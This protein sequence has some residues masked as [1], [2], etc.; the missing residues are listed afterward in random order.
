MRMGSRSEES[1]SRRQVFSAIA[2]VTAF[3]AVAEPSNAVKFE[4]SM[5]FG[6]L[7]VPVYGAYSGKYDGKG[8][9]NKYEGIKVGIPFNLSPFRN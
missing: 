2:A 9:G 8:I 4:P 3:G 6:Q 1:V 7:P 5:S